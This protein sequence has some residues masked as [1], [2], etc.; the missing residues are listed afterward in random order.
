VTRIPL[1]RVLA[2]GGLSSFGPLALD[3]YL[4]G[5]PAL[6]TDLGASEAAGQLSLSTCMIGLALGQLLVGP[7]T[8]RTG[9]RVPLLAGVGLFAVTAGLCALAPSIEVLLVLRLLGGLAGGAGIVIARAMVRDLYSGET[10]ARMFSLLMIVSNV[11]PVVAPLLG[12]LLLRVVD[13]RGVFG[14]LAVV[15]VLLLVA[16]LTQPET[17]PPTRRHA[18][19]LRVTGTALAAVLR[20]RTF[21]VPA[22]VQGI[23]VCGMFV[24]IATATFVLQGTYGLS[25]QQFAVVFGLNAVAIL[26]M[27]RISLALVRRAGPRR[28]VS[29]GLLIALAAAAAMLAGVLVSRSVWA[30]LPPLLVLVSCTGML[31][32]NATA[33]ALDGQG[34]RAGSASAVIGLAQFLFA[35]VVPPLASLGGVTPVVMA[36]TILATA[37]VAALLWFVARARSPHPVSGKPPSGRVRS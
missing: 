5:L 36:A 7:L 25:A 8:D 20:D 27:G 2:L 34:E 19:G 10:A 14:A 33:L 22:V 35:A 13:W 9:R 21:V 31:M 37:S 1:T 15:G 24:Y 32:P 16:A 6:T 17:L 4:P 23:G 28:L 30:L 3:L 12:G 26:V 18:G 29:T 11:A